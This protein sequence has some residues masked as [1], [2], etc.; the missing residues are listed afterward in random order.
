[1]II[2]K[3]PLPPTLIYR[4][5][6]ENMY[7]KSHK[8]LILKTIDLI[9]NIRYFKPDEILEILALISL[10]EDK[11][12]SNKALEVIREFAEYDYNVL[13]KT[14][15][16]YS[17]Q[18]KILDLMLT[19]SP[20]ERLRQI[21]FI[22]I[23]AKELLS[24]SVTGSELTA[25]HTV[26]RYYGAVAPNDLLKQIRLETMELL[27][28]LYQSTGD[29]IIHLRLVQVLANVA[30]TPSNVAYG[31]DLLQMIKD[32]LGY[33]IDIYT[34]IVFQDNGKMIDNLAVVI[35]IDQSLYWINKSERLRSTQS[36]EVRQKIL[37]EELYQ[38]CRLLVTDGITDRELGS[39]ETA[40][41][42]RAEE[43]E[44]LISSIEEPC[45]EQWSD[46]L[47]KIALQHTLID[48]WQFHSFI[49]FLQKLTQSKPQ[50]ADKLL[51]KAFKN[52]LPIKHF[53]ASFLCG[54]RIN[55]RLDLW[56]KYAKRIIDAQDV[57]LTS[58]IV[59][60][61]NLPEGIDLQKNI[62]NKDIDLL[63]NIV[64]KQGQFSFLERQDDHVL[65]STL[66]EAIARNHSIA[67]E[68]IEALMMTEIENN[69]KYLA[70]FFKQFSIIIERSGM[71]IQELQPET[72]RFLKEK[73]FELPD[74]DWLTQELLLAIGQ[75]D[76][77]RA[78]LD[79]FLKRIYRD[80]E[81]K[82]RRLGGERYE[83]IPYHLNSHLCEFIAQ[84]PEY[85]KI[86]GEWV[87]IMTT[88]WSL[89]NTHVARFLHGIGKG[90][91]EIVMSLIEKGDDHSLI[92]AVHAIHSIEGG[93]FDLYLEIVRR[94]D[95]TRILRLVESHMHT[96][97][98]VIGEYGFAEAYKSKAKKLEKYQKGESKRVRDF[99]EY[100]IQIFRE[101]EKRE[102]RQADEE[103]QL[104]Q[105]E[106]EG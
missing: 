11:E 61:L 31:D 55:I 70:T 86:A 25:P 104:G 21:T 102:L 24:S 74:I 27:Y 53:T 91:K 49:L 38:L 103:R 5:K 29:P 41:Q 2:K 79:V 99:V 10:R 26:T 23:V 20:E 81:K 1:M 47:N 98:I 46:K 48:D 13:T 58:A 75:Y 77:L 28:G 83:A 40:K 97:G 7:G 105:I 67:P 18:R 87:A 71:N 69:P 60:S 34:R 94:T 82:P 35:I 96:T 39:W 6:N 50:V 59:Y 64:K 89:Y 78:I 16:G 30:D 14:R 17:P 62:R 84:H 37:D 101:N 57:P 8:D 42:K 44:K 9:S 36:D 43:I 76:E 92:K 4:F 51:D 19:W 90:F 80:V 106:F 52:D 68:K 66:I 32:D 15:F 93:D 95:N 65:H 100:M 63:H 85:P 54:F 22:E 88:E 72:T 45:I 12:I 3:Q 73:M 33:L 56:D